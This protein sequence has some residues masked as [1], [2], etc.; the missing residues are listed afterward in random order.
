[1]SLPAGIEEMKD[2]NGKKGGGGSEEAEGVDGGA[3]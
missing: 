3:K 2:R 1:M